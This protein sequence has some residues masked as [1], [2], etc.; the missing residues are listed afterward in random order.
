MTLKATASTA[1]DALVRGE[2]AEAYKLAVAWLTTI[3]HSDVVWDEAS[4]MRCAAVALQAAVEGGGGAPGSSSSSSS[5]S[6]DGDE[7]K[8]DTGN[9]RAVSRLRAAGE[10]VV[11]AFAPRALPSDVALLWAALLAEEGEDDEADAVLEAAVLRASTSPHDVA[12][13]ARLRNTLSCSPRAESQDVHTPVEDR[14]QGTGARCRL[15][16]EEERS[17]REGGVGPVVTSS[18]QLQQQRSG[19]DNGG[20]WSVMDVAVKCAVAVCV[21]YA[22][23][24]EG[25]ILVRNM[26]ANSRNRPR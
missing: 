21:I 8:G 23:A 16:E 5:S 2:S 9:I 14:T 1:E 12:R 25:S 13:L 26:R 11:R 4:A 10:V 7:V 22:I 17:K 6:R 20:E 15:N 3:E 24:V 19:G 18:H